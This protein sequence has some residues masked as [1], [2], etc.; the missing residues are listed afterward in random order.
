MLAQVS[1]VDVASD[2]PTEMNV[3]KIAG[4]SGSLRKASSNSGVV[5]AYATAFEQLNAEGYRNTRVEFS[6]VDISKLPL[7]NTDVPAGDDVKE[8]TANPEYNYGVSA[9]MKNALDW[10]SGPA[11]GNFW[12]GKA[13]AIAGAGGGMGGLRAQQHLRDY[14]NFLKLK[15]LDQDEILIK[16][17]DNPA[18]FDKDTGDLISE[19]WQERIKAHAAK[20]IDWSLQLNK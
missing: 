14:F 1:T 2:A 11:G 12:S 5:R 15:P 16:A 13:V 18:P 4:I 19:K 9:A 7:L 17:F 10:A 20:L 6:I 3:L 8:F